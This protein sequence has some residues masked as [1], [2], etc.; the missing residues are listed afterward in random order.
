[1]NVL[2][3]HE[4][5]FR[6][7]EDQVKI[8]FISYLIIRCIV[9]CIQKSIDA[10]FNK[11]GNEVR[12]GTLLHTFINETISVVKGWA[13]CIINGNGGSCIGF[14]LRFSFGLGHSPVNC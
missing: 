6:L 11:V 10:Y 7:E 3:F 14:L 12:D 2:D 9:F 5:R 8:Y 13:E 4:L 1:M